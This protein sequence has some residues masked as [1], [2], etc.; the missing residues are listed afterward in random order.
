MLIIPVEQLDEWERELQNYEATLEEMANASLDMKEELGAVEQWFRVLTEAERT[1]ALYSLLQQATQV[2]I[3][4]FLTVLQQMASKTPINH[5]LSPASFEKGK[6]CHFTMIA[7]LDAMQQKLNSAMSQLTFDNPPRRTN[8]NPPVTPS[9]RN[10]R[11]LDPSTIQAM[12]P[13]AAAALAHQRSLL[14]SNRNSMNGLPA[15]NAPSAANA[16]RSPALQAAKDAWPSSTETP[17]KIRPRSAE[18]ASWQGT[19]TPPISQNIKSPRVQNQSTPSI[20]EDLTSP[21]GIP[22]GGSWASMVNTPVVPMFQNPHTTSQRGDTDLGNAT[23]MKLAAWNA[24]NVSSVSGGVI[25]LDSDVRKFRRGKTQQSHQQSNDTLATPTHITS[26]ARGGSPSNILMYDEHGQLLQLTPQRL[27]QM[28]GVPVQQSSPLTT[29][30]RPTSPYPPGFAQFQHLPLTSPVGLGLGPQQTYLQ[31]Y[32]SSPILAPPDFSQGYLSDHSPDRRGGGSP[33]IGGKTKLHAN[34][35]RRAAST[36]KHQEDP[37][38]PA[39]LNDIPSWLRS[40]RLHK[41]TENLADVKGGVVAL[42]QLTD[43]DLE[44]RGVSALGARRKLLKVFE[45]IKN[46]GQG[47]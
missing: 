7:D 21:F 35:G 9:P 16:P 6:S 30:S 27:G 13:D 24:S 37:L 22:G 4:F 39:L 10:S 41:Y 36:V 15:T 25:S 20:T 47:Q 38:D 1:A 32:D 45:M 40:L 3:R 28:R 33:G 43:E 5:L 14:T 19:A 26:A 18:L 12:F 2:Q 44:K 29:K 23:A 31:P 11:H 8:S 46:G 42:A 17:M 34:N